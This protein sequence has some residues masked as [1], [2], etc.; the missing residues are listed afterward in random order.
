MGQKLL[1]DLESYGQRQSPDSPPLADTAG[2]GGGVGALDLGARA[3]GQVSCKRLGPKRTAR[4]AGR[5]GL[6]RPLQ[7]GAPTLSGSWQTIRG[8]SVYRRHP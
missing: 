4:R 8:H 1:G 5:F 6:L 3:G 7:D 2:V